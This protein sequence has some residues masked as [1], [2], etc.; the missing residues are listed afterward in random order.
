MQNIKGKTVLA[1][2]VLGIMLTA[3]CVS[4][5]AAPGTSDDPIVSLGFVE[6]RL[7]QVQEYLNARIDMLDPDMQIAMQTFRLVEVPAGNRLAGVEGTEMILR[8]GTA[9][10]FSTQ[11]GGLANTTTGLDLQDGAPV[12]ANSLLV[13]PR[14]D[15]R[16]MVA[17]TDLLVMVKGAFT[18]GSLVE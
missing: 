17:E 3:V 9:T 10:I 13:V 5:L 2:S 6:Q 18:G 8:Q 12:P 14:S 11:L 7:S 15:G 4:I 16:G 1:A